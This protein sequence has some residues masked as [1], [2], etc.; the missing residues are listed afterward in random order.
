MLEVFSLDG[1]VCYD[2]FYVWA[3]IVRPID[4]AWGERSFEDFGFWDEWW[5]DDFLKEKTN[6]W[7]HS[8]VHYCH[9]SPFQGKCQWGDWDGAEMDEK[10]WVGGVRGHSF[11]DNGQVGLL[12]D[13]DE[14]T[15]SVYI[16]GESKGVMKENLS[17]PYC[18]TVTLRAMCSMHTTPN[19][20]HVGIER[21]PLPSTSVTG[22]GQPED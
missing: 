14:G 2:M 1:N 19:A 18:W 4:R 6:D 3:G 7:E 11:L 22:G 9:Y 12:L 20:Q 10:Q 5:H 21:L 13:L 17:G 15:L 16:N 8:N